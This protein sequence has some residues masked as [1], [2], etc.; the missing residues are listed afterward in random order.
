[1][2]IFAIS[3]IHIE[4]KPFSV[5]KY[6]GDADIVVL[7]GDIHTKSRG[8]EWAKKTFSCPVI[9]VPGN[10]EGWMGHWDNTIIKMK[11]MA[12]NSNIYVLNNDSVEIDGVR[13]LG[14]TLWTTFDAWPNQNDAMVASGEGRNHYGSGMRDYRNIRTGS[15]RHIT[16]KDTLEWSL[17]SKKWLLGEAAKNFNGETVVVTHHAPVLESLRCGKVL[18]IYDAAYANNWEDGV[19]KINAV[20]WIHGHIHTPRH[21]TIGNTLMVAHPLGYSGENI[22][23]LHNQYIEILNKKATVLNY[24][25][26]NFQETVFLKNRKKTFI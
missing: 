21:H 2:K 25:D 9:Y 19:L 14:S 4:T 15:Y 6:T 1:M 10:H 13:F 22:P 8:V 7:A 23:H 16:T 24:Q 11:E 5:W 20:C 26:D 17:K 12:K 3:D 18:D